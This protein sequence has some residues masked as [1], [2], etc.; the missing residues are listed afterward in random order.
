MTGAWFKKYC[1][2]AAFLVDLDSNALYD[3]ARNRSM[4]RCSDDRVKLLEADAAFDDI[5]FLA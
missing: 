5:R 2:D 1:L 3:N 4:M